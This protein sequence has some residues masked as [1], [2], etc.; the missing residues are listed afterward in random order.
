MGR[1]RGA[2]VSVSPPAGVPN[3][4]VRL[5]WLGGEHDFNIAQY[6]TL[7]QLEAKCDAGVRAIMLRIETD[8]WKVDDL[9]EV[10]R[11][12]L[13]GAG[14]PPDQAQQL[15]KTY[16]DDCPLQH[17]KQVAYQIIA[18]AMIGVPG[19]NSVGKRRPARAKTETTDSS[20]PKSTASAPR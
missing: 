8:T 5:A 20:A 13:I 9:R 16:V 4:K 6:K 2:G 12:G 17:S 19:D 3:G 18:A 11:L 14:T 1:R 15:I 10:I 7:L